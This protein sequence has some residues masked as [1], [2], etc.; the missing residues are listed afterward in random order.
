MI[1][2]FWGLSWR[3]ESKCFATGVDLLNTYPAYSNFPLFS[4]SFIWRTFSKLRNRHSITK[5]SNFSN[6]SPCLVT[7]GEAPTYTRGCWI[8]QGQGRRPLPGKGCEEVTTRHNNSVITKKTCTYLCNQHKLCNDGGTEEERMDCC[9][10][11][12]KP[13]SWDGCEYVKDRRN[14]RDIRIVALEYEKDGEKNAC[15]KSNREELTIRGKCNQLV[16]LI[17]IANN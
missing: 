13:A 4:L 11:E 9:P 12:V 5:T 17:I 7:T 15:Y 14:V 3:A 1:D 8:G 10:P 6:C 16:N 2:K